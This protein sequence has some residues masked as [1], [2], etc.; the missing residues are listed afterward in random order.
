MWRLFPLFPAESRRGLQKGSWCW[1]PGSAVGP[2]G[3]SAAQQP[4]SA[5]RGRP[6]NSDALCLLG[7]EDSSSNATAVG[8]RRRVYCLFMPGWTLSRDLWRW[9]MKEPEHMKELWAATIKWLSEPFNGRWG[10]SSEQHP[11][12]CDWAHGEDTQCYDNF[13]FLPFL[14]VC[15][16]YSSLFQ[17]ARGS[18]FDE[19]ISIPNWGG[20]WS[21][22]CV[23]ECVYWWCADV[24][25]CM[26]VC[27]ERQWLLLYPLVNFLDHFFFFLMPPLWRQVQLTHSVIPLLTTAV[28]VDKNGKRQNTW[29]EHATRTLWSV[30]LSFSSRHSVESP[31]VLSYSVWPA[32]VWSGQKRREGAPWRFSVGM[33]SL[34]KY[35]FCSLGNSR[36][37]CEIQ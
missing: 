31:S 4:G 36:G 17:R 29:C 30:E 16:H 37:V 24:S 27:R 32:L 34:W 13:C 3:G 20:H 35:F 19:E 6:M 8:T 14:R 9:T 1:E 2:L 25:E 21:Y 12:G 5:G 28:C 10:A 15:I 22:V 11:V 18:L 26:R 7:Q 23:P 33:T